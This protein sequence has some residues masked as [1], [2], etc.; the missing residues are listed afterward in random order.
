MKNILLIF[1]T[2]LMISCSSTRFVSD[3]EWI[4]PPETFSVFIT[5]PFVENTDDVKDDL[6]EHADNFIGWFKSSLGQ[7]LEKISGKTPIIN[8]IEDSLLVFVPLQLTKKNT[9]QIPLPDTTFKAPGIAFF[10]NPIKVFRQNDLSVNRHTTG[11][12]NHKLV[13][14][15]LYSVI[16]TDNNKIL[17]YGILY[18]TQTFHIAMT[19]GNWEK[20]IRKLAKQLLE[21]TPLSKKR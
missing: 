18:S 11:M 15:A 19:R 4:N 1:I 10:I 6:P 14:N 17:A 20:S 7:E 8:Q 2:I 21:G 5:E 16:D 3:Q 12:P 13:F 9:I